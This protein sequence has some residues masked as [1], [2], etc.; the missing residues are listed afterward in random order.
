MGCMCSTWLSKRG[1]SKLASVKRRRDQG[2]QNL[3]LV[4][5]M[6]E[7]VEQD[8]DLEMVEKVQEHPDVHVYQ[9]EWVGQDH[10]LLLD[11][12]QDQPLLEVDQ[13][14]SQPLPLEVDQDQ[15]HQGYHLDTP[16]HG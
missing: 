2:Q 3:E 5:E 12:D 9:R 6:V 10:H 14:L 7:M 1:R 11:Q 15:V 13:G 4:V 16:R 8:L